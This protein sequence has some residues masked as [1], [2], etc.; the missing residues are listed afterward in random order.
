MKRTSWISLIVIC[1][2]AAVILF[3][4]LNPGT[5]SDEDQVHQVLE[6]AET[7]VENKNLGLAFSLVSPNYHDSAGLRAD[8]IKM[9][10]IDK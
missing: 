3:L 9:Q 2:A 6:N 4:H 1:L 5:L 10:I 8:G 7:S